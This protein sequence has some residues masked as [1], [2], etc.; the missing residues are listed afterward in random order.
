M[1]QLLYKSFQKLS[2]SLNYMVF[3]AERRAL[4]HNE[5]VQYRDLSY[6]TSHM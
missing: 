3:D 4:N 5:E 1:V 2:E 6:F